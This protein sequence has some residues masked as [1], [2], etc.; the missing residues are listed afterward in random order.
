[1]GTS[2]NRNLREIYFAF[3]GYRKEETVQ[4][5]RD[6]NLS[7]EFKFDV[8]VS[9]G[10]SELLERHVPGRAARAHEHFAL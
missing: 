6:T 7:D 9:L 8:E 3:V 5:S 2:G 10:G 1:M 4:G